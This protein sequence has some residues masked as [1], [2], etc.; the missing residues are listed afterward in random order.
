MRKTRPGT[1]G[2][3]VFRP[4]RADRAR[5]C[6]KYR[7]P[8]H[9]RPR[10]REPPRPRGTRRIR[11][12]PHRTG[13]RRAGR[14]CSTC[15]ATS[16]STRS[17]DAA[18]PDSIRD[19]SPRRRGRSR[20]ARPRR[21]RGCAGSARRNEVFTSLIGLGYTRHVHAA[22]DPAQRAREPGLVHRVHAVPAR[23]LA[24]PARGAAQLPDDGRG[25]HRHGDRRTRRCSTRR[26]R[27]PRR[28][29]CG[30]AGTEAARR[31]S[32]ST[33]TAIRR[34]SRSSRRAPSRSASRSSSAIRARPRS[35]SSSSACSLQY[36]GSSGRVRDDADVVER[37]SRRR[38]AG[39]G[40]GR[41]ARAGAAA[42]AGRDRRRHRRRLR[43][44]LRGA[45]RCSAAR[46]PRS[47]RCATS[48]SARCPAGSSACRSTR[49]DAPRMRLALQ[50][51]EQHIRREKATSNICTAQVLL[52][53][54]AGLYAVYH[55]P[56]GLD[57]IARRVH[58]LTAIL[59][60]RRSASAAID[61]V[62]DTFFDT[63]TVRVPG[64]RRPI[65]EAA[66]DAA[67]QPPRRRRRHA[68]HHARRDDDRRGRRMRCGARS[69]CR[70]RSPTSTTRCAR[71]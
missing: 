67:H 62:T 46:T 4:G 24:G 33:P 49:R 3:S 43:A 68:R 20:S 9:E 47:S 15:S 60:A 41:S 38:R 34:R 39:H 25:P 29:R 32:S 37:V 22:G 30:A 12:P 10:A 13:R 45:A 5:S 21:S 18:V 17:I 2:S 36:P 59:A 26:P 14:R 58:R 40:R 16:R 64:A 65:A 27:R 63:I 8:D 11:P 1:A 31:R 35:A 53:V 55:G 70:L 48:T 56:E 61:V 44:A 69:V 54:I 23:D 6:L 71:R 7:R 19:L 52:A 42:L 28:W 51:R 57:R 50:T 66:R